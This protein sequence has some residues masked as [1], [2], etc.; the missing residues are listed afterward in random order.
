MSLLSDQEKISLSSHFLW[1]TFQSK[2]LWKIEWMYWN[3]LWIVGKLS[4]N[5][6][7]FIF[8]VQ[9]VVKT[10]A[11]SYVPTTNTGM[12]SMNNPACH[13]AIVLAVHET[14]SSPKKLR[15]V[16]APKLMKPR[17]YSK[18][19]VEPLRFMNRLK[20]EEPIYFCVPMS[21]TTESCHLFLEDYTLW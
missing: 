19:K 7:V 21:G 12:V 1:N 14:G 18:W 5:V 16:L 15:A 20:C 4:Y 6:L 3:Y 13:H 9:P 8:S 10:S 2:W 11:A 17:L